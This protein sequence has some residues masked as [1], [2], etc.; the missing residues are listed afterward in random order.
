MKLFFVVPYILNFDMNQVNNYYQMFY[1][2]YNLKTIK[3]NKNNCALLKA[4][5][6]EEINPE[7]LTNIE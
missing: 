5:K 2:C 3:I 4:I 6:D 1:N 7:I